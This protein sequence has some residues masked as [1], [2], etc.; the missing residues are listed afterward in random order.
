MS[1]K[2]KKKHNNLLSLAL[3]NFYDEFADFNED[4]A[5]LCDAF[6]CMVENHE[7]LD[8][9]STRGLSRNAYWLKRRTT[10]LK[11]VIKHIR[12]LEQEKRERK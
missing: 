7:Y 11:E 6:A 12:S 1:K 5:F 4:C 2:K 3:L 10:K 9:D 8:Q